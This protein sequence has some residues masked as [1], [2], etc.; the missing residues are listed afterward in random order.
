MRH[1]LED[2]EHLIR[3][4]ALFLGAFL[5]FLLARAALVPKGFGDLG[6]YR[7]GALADV[8]SRPVAF[9]GRGA[10]TDCHDDSAAKL[11]DGKHAGVGC[12]ACHGAQAAHAADP[13]SASAS[14]PDTR[15]LCPVC[16]ARNAAK[17]KTFPQVDIKAH[18][19]GNA[20]KDC[21][22]PHHPDA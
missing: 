21:H 3:L 14:M 15:E 22:D 2:R 4:A 5:V 9:A 6:H 13:T 7:S 20:C 19:D 10:C 11:H 16:H 1:L 8:A 17:P 12:E 18:A